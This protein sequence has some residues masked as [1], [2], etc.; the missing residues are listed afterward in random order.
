MKKLMGLLVMTALVMGSVSA[1]KINM[2]YRTQASIATIVN[3]ASGTKVDFF[4]LDE[5]G[6]AYDKAAKDDLVIAL[7]GENAGASVTI[8]PTIDTN[9]AASPIALGI[10]YY[11]GWVN[12]GQFKVTAGRFDSRYTGR[13]SNFAGNFHG[14]VGEYVKLG[15]IG[16]VTM[17]K[18][19]DNF[20]TMGNATKTHSL[21]GEYTFDNLLI[22]LGFQEAN[23]ALTDDMNWAPTSLG[24]GYKLDAFGTIEGIFRLMATDTYVF[25]AYVRPNALVDGLDAVVGFTMGMETATSTNEMGID[26][27]AQ[28]NISDAFYVATNVNFT[29]F[30]SDDWGMWISGNGTYKVNDLLTGQLTVSYIDEAV[31]SRSIN[32]LIGAELYTMSGCSISTGV[33]VQYNLDAEKLTAY[34]PCVLRVKL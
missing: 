10:D 34:I 17:I 11:F 16:G 3:D 9:N 4:N 20:G 7:S 24:I 21:I 26:V 2:N 25:G 12:F 23:I 18:D 32:A 29:K 19:A 1:Q 6:V 15:G 14:V 22:K 5:D 28:Y 33:E 30:V 31:N 27:R 13:V 8:Q